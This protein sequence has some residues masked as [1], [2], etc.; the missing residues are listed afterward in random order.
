MVAQSVEE[1]EEGSAIRTLTFVAAVTEIVESVADYSAQER[2]GLSHADAVSETQDYADSFIVPTPD[3]AKVSHG[4]ASDTVQ[5]VAETQ[6]YTDSF[7]APTPER[8]KGVNDVAGEV[9]ETQAY[10]DSFAADSA[11]NVQ[12]RKSVV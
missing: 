7:V 6:A 5:E 3:R 8:Q 11:D 1:V 10:T 12:D 9:A 2:L 4:D